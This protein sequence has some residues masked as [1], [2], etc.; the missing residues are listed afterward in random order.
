MT[1]CGVG[2]HSHADRGDDFYPT[3]AEAVHALLAAEKKWLPKEAVWEPACGDGSIVNVLR[4]FGH[5]VRATD[6]VDRGCPDS[7]VLNFFEAPPFKTY[8]SIITNPPFKLAREFV[9]QA[10]RLSPYVA[11]LLRLSFLEGA[12]RKPWFEGLPLARVHVASRRLPMMHRH[13]W[14]GPKAGSAVCHAW[15]VWDERHEGRPQIQWFDWKE[16]AAANDNT[17]WREV[18]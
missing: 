16:A 12:A 3:P 13:S 9:D 10:L 14:T 18:A 7:S 1:I 11:M 6:I 17:P 2:T 8:H 4:Y 15:F 5:Q